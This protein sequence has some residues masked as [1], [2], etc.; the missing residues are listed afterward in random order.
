MAVCNRCLTLLLYYCTVVLPPLLPP[1]AVTV[2]ELNFQCMCVYDG[3]FQN[4][5]EKSLGI[6]GRPTFANITPVAMCSGTRHTMKSVSSQLVANAT[7]KPAKKVLTH[8][9]KID[10]FAPRPSCILVMS[11]RRQVGCKEG[12][13]G[14]CMLEKS[15]VYNQMS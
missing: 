13:Q 5:R 3:D 7:M 6:F 12:H 11:L 2:P 10:S 14:I 4:I 1:Y 8:C 15:N 9:A